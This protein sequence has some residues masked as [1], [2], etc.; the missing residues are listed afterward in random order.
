[1]AE[2]MTVARPYAKAVFQLAREQ[3]AYADWSECLGIV[4][5]GASDPEFGALLG[6]PK[7]SQPRLAE[8]LAELCGERA[9]PVV[10]NFL[11]LLAENGRLA[12]LP[13]IAVEYE[14]L[15]AAAENVA[16]VAVTS[17]VA[18]SDEQR[19]SIGE[20]MKKRLGKDIRLHCD[21]DASLL[22]GA[23]IRAGDLVIDGSLRGRLERLTNAVTH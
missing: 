10:R 12:Y 4:S 11:G 8:L 20:A 22:G 5:E 16:D 2:K 21:I 6:D 17:A 15:R 14:R 13:E 7:V 3:S 18:L 23:I 9:A 1:M 19:A